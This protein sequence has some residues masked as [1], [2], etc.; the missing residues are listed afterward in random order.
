MRTLGCFITTC[1]MATALL[2]LVPVEACAQSPAAK[3]LEKSRS[4]AREIEELRKILNGP[5]QN[6][7]LS[8]FDAMVKSGDDAL[9]MIALETGLA[10]ADGVMR[11][12]AF[13]GLV[14]SLDNIYLTLKV[15]TTAPKNVVE[16]SEKF[17]SDKGTSFVVPLKEKNKE[18]GT[19]RQGN[20]EGQVSGFEFVFRYNNEGEPS[21]VL[22]L[23]DDN[24]L[25]GLVRHK[26]G[27]QFT[28]SARLR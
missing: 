18:T 7:R 1:I 14:M 6:M 19:F 24:T 4:Q 26:F 15:D 9:R 12:M 13:K 2:T 8:T 21:G 10:S 16:K 25:S 27:T 22:S 23:K 20:W 5:D 28:A 11:A 3:I 17:I